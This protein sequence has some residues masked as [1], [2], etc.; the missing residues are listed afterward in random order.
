[1]F[2]VAMLLLVGT[3]PL[4]AINSDFSDVFIANCVY[5][6]VNFLLRVIK[7]PVRC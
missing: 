7:G 1:M 6:C 2:S 4:N 3:F 5:S